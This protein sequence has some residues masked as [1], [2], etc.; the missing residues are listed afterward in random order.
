MNWEEA[1]IIHSGEKHYYKRKL[2]EASFMAL[3]NKK[4]LSIQ[5]DGMWILSS[6]DA[7]KYILYNGRGSKIIVLQSHTMHKAITKAKLIL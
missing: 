2:I 7:P 1:K 4:R 5:F 6:S 3:T